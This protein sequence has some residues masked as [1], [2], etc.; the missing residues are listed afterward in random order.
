MTQW[1]GEKNHDTK[2]FPEL[3]D[4]GLNGFHDPNRQK[5]ISV[6]QNY[7][8]KLF[9]KNPKYAQDSDYV[10][11]AQ[12][13]HERNRFEGQISVTSKRGKRI[14]MKDGTTKLKNNDVTD[15]FKN[16]PGTPAYWKAFR[17]ETFARI[18]TGTVVE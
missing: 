12:Q 6:H 13:H 7:N 3:F 14:T 2:A 15:V 1:F 11:V 8:S 17:N 9:N 5:P 4:D 16:I 10:F 18:K